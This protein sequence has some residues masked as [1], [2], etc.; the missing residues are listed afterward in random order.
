MVNQRA[1]DGESECLM[2]RVKIAHCFSFYNDI[3][4]YHQICSKTPN[5]LTTEMNSNIFLL[6]YLQSTSS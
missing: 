2:Y 1:N 4:V 6:V 5:L 3:L